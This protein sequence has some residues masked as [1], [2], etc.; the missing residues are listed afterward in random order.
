MQRRAWKSLV[1]LTTGVALVA[2]ARL[3][4]ADEHGRGY[5][6]Q[7]PKGDVERIINR[8]EANSDQFTKAFDKALD[9]SELDGR[10]AKIS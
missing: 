7:Y 10:R 9:R 2:M 1:V 4:H 3:S 6:E 5:G 8:V